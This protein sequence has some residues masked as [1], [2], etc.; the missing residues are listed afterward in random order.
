MLIFTGVHCGEPYS[1]TNSR[2]RVRGHYYND[3]TVYDCL[4]GYTIAGDPTS[5]CQEDGHWSVPP[6]CH[7]N[8]PIS[9]ITVRKH[10]NQN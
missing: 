2:R 9:A 3:S 6:E 5:Y 1:V 4:L 8:F 10:N 7:G